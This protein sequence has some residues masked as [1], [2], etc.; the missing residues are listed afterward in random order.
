MA[1]EIVSYS[2]NK[3]LPITPQ[4]KMADVIHRDYRLIPIIGRFGIDFGF[5]NKSVGEVCDENDIN[6]WFFLEIVNSYHNPQYFPQEQLQKFSA[7]Q[8][9]AYLS[10]THSYYK[11]VKIPEIQGYI[12]EMEKKA[13]EE[14]TNNVKLLNDFFKGY[15]EE[16]EL[17]LEHEDKEIF[18]YVI[19]LENAL[20]E[21][22][23]SIDLKKKI[24]E[25][26]IEDYER[27]HEDVEVKLSD[28]KNLIIKFLPPVLCKEL[29][30]KL[31]TELYRLENDLENHSRIEDNVLVPKVK[32]LEQTILEG[33]GS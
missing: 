26:P 4:M 24:I 32:M 8:I 17:H 3:N 30:K 21:G 27:G 18:P 13:S 19:E 2:M 1:S 29:C 20:E 28:L 10:S 33:S 9:I 11:D 7:K 6:T 31:L 5:G 22:K 16:L 23:I 12:D 14:H 15:V 25:E